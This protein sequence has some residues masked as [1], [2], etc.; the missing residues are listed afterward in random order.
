[1]SFADGSSDYCNTAFMKIPLPEDVTS[2][3]FTSS[4]GAVEGRCTFSNGNQLETFAFT[5]T[6]DISNI[7]HSRA[8]MFNL[9]VGVQSSGDSVIAGNNVR[10]TSDVYGRKIINADGGPDYDPFVVMD[11]DFKVQYT[12]GTRKDLL[13]VNVATKDIQCYNGTLT[14]SGGFDKIRYKVGSVTY[15]LSSYIEQHIDSKLGDIETA[16]NNI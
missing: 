10:I 15:D 13:N 2:I 4:D 9:R 16:I 7:D 6:Y 12:Q 5:N 14:L 1:M 3:S 11:R 8:I